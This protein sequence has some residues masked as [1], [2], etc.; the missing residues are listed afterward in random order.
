MCCRLTAAVLFRGE[1]P[2]Q[3]TSDGDNVPAPHL[4]PGAGASSSAVS[5]DSELLVI[6]A[7]CTYELNKWVRFPIRQVTQ[8]TH[9]ATT[10]PAEVISTKMLT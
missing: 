8:S 3:L 9:T 6:D 2:G 1:G 10:A 5:A 7:L 4:L